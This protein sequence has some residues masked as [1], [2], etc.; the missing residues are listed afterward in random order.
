MSKY[1]PEHY[2]QGDI[3]PWDFISSQGLGFLEGNVI[4]YITRAGKKD[5]ESRLDD[6]L[7]AKAYLHKLISLEVNAP[8]P[9][10]S[11]SPVPSSDGTTDQRV[12]SEY[13]RNPNSFNY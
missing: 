7:K 8:G 9:T 4:K 12:L 5:T 13:L 6:L 3:E 11:S 2:R 1:N 10:S